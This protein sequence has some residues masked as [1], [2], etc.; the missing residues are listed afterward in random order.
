MIWN[1]TKDTILMD[2]ILDR[3]V[4]S[5]TVNSIE[6]I[7]CWEEIASVCNLIEGFRVTGESVCKHFQ[8]IHNYA[9]HIRENSKSFSK[10]QEPYDRLI[11]KLLSI[12][13]ETNQIKCDTNMRHHRVKL[14]GIGKNNLQTKIPERT[15]MCTTNKRIKTK[16]KRSGIQHN[17]EDETP[18]KFKRKV[19]MNN[20]HQEESVT[21]MEDYTGGEFGTAFE[22]ISKTLLNQ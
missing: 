2:M 14:N 4:L 6:R 8:S 17:L 19:K 21:T 18:K 1:K 9:L 5:Y 20:S 12:S 10:S 13:D 15:D 3:D 16:A 11:E 7:N 22:C